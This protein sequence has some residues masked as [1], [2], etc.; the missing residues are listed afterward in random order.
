MNE[1]ITVFKS[2]EDFAVETLSKIASRKPNSRV[3]AKAF[4]RSRKDA[5][6]FLKSYNTRVR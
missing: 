6:T 5:Q 2:W 4:A 1:K 3:A